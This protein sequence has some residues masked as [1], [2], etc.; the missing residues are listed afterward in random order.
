MADAFRYRAF[1]SYS[2]ADDTNASRLH[3]A[4]EAYVLPRRV[5]QAHAL[6]ARLAPIF[7]DIEE[8]EA[9]S[10]LATRLRDAMDESQWMIVLCSPAAAASRYVNE[11]VTYFLGKHGA[12]RVL[13]ALLAGEPAEAF[14]PALRALDE[15][16]L[17]A[18]F[19]PGRDFDLAKL[20]LVAALASVG[21]N[22]LRDREAQRARRRRTI[23][24]L[25]LAAAAL[26]PL[27]AWDLLY[28]EHVQYF[29]G[30]ERRD[31]IWKGVDE[32][33]ESEARHRNRNYRFVRHGRLNPPAEVR[34]TTGLDTCYAWGLESVLG[35]PL[36]YEGA[37]HYL[38][39]PACSATFE[40]AQDGRIQ[41]EVKRNRNG[42]PLEGITYTGPD[43][44]QFTLEGFGASG[45]ATGVYY[46]QFTRYKDG[47]LKGL[48]REARFFLSRD[49]P[50][51]NDE[52][53]FGYRYE[54][55]ANGRRVHEVPLD[56]KGEPVAEATSYEYDAQ[57]RLA[58]ERAADLAG[59]PRQ[60]SD[61]C[62]GDLHQ[63]DDAGNLVRLT[64]LG[65]DGSP[66][67]NARGEASQEYRYDGNG[68]LV[69]W[70]AVDAAGH[71]VAGAEGFAELRIAYDEHG[72]PTEMA[73]YDEHGAPAVDSEGGHGWKA[74]HDA[75]GNPIEFSYFD[76]E[77]KPTC[78]RS[79]V[80]IWRLEYDARGLCVG[81][82]YLSQDGR[83]VLIAF[84][85]G[86]R[87]K[88]DERGNATEIVRL[89]LDG[90]P[91]VV[92]DQGYAIVRLRRN[93]RGAIVQRDFFDA[94]AKPILLKSGQAGGRFE[95]DDLGDLVEARFVGTKGELVRIDEGYA[96]Q[97]RKYDALGQPIER[98]FYDEHRKPVLHRDG[99]YGFES[100][101]DNRGLEIERRY[102]GPDGNPFRSP[103]TGTFGVRYARNPSG[104]VEAEIFL[105][106]SGQ[107][108]AGTALARIE[109]I[110]DDHLREVEVRYESGDGKAAQ[111]RDSG[112]S[113]LRTEYDA[114]GRTI[115][116][117]CLDAAGRPMDRR[118]RGWAVKAIGYESGRRVAERFYDAKGREVRPRS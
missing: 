1:L 40:Y 41:R 58:R 102:L 94:S 46:V 35:T 100:S 90:K 69:R 74:R 118:D 63:Y 99:Y 42:F 77:R 38:N 60:R 109:H 26:A 59:H 49:N 19:R 78:I 101:Y 83:P 81:Q 50:R 111:A 92:P 107:P 2:H 33:S 96:I 114:T 97:R 79:G 67:T 73:M 27:A 108:L 57:G 31:G 12:G 82:S 4:L 76:R 28:R 23:A 103:R 13:C 34:A 98:T 87:V 17:A 70:H 52:R 116:E 47:P 65:A 112:C 56:G 39:S 24:G 21:F 20:K 7:R 106:A 71:L 55:D 11:E 15:E 62:Y 86:M 66:A 14:P 3:R 43:V 84:A 61:G 95:F 37:T 93:E 54:Y 75:V 6:P 51:P 85:A 22:E 105:D 110:Y 80:C 45:S 115:A 32:V 53:R 89:G 16:P 48:E 68:N 9:A 88:Y 18:D 30:Y 44:A 113:A 25:A 91:F 10:G 117:R 104:D 72:W 29:R 36:G 8:L 5:R 64:C